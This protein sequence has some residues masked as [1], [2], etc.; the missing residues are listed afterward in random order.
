MPPEELVWLLAAAFGPELPPA[1]AEA[2]TIPRLAGEFDLGPRIVA[3]H[4]VEATRERLGPAA[5]E[6][7]AAHRRAVALALAGE[8]LARRVGELAAGH[9]LAIL[10]L[11]GYALQLA[12]LGPAGWRPFVDLDVL[13]SRAGA[14]ELSDL[15]AGEGWRAAAGDGNPQHLP[16]LIAP[17]GISVDLHFRLRGVRVGAERWATLDELLAADL[18]LPA[19]GAGAGAWVPRP[20]L[21]AAHLAVHALEQHGHRPATYPLLRAVADVADLAAGEGAEELQSGARPLV[22]ESLADDEL[23]ALFTLASLL[24]EGRLPAADRAQEAAAGALLRHIVAGVGDPVYRRS[25]AIDHTAGRLRQAREDGE[26]MRYISRKLR[27]PGDEPAAGSEKPARD[28]GSVGRKLMRPIQLAARFAAAAAARLRR[29][30]D[31]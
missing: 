2:E 5:G 25:L 21:L 18:C 26:L 20:P 4:G 1:P 24:G 19:P 11:K 22:R 3:R 8:R 17:E 31:R 29:T 16:A 9:G 12:A 23:A 7:V 14:G 6:L 27:V 13:V 15:L 28:P 30:F 10:F